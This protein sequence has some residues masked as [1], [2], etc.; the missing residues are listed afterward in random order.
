MNYDH[1]SSGKS[2]HD[3]LRTD[4]NRIF[5]YYQKGVYPSAER[6]IVIGDIHGDW[7]AFVN[8]LK[9]SKII[10]DKLEYIGGKTHIVQVGDVFDRKPRE[11]DGSCDEDSEMKIISLIMDLQIKSYLKGGGYHPIIGNHELMNVLG[12]FSYASPLGLAHFGGAKGR[13][14][15]FQ[16]GSSLSKYMACGWNPIVKIGGWLFCHGGISKKVA[17]KYDIENINLIMR[18]YL[19]G[20]T[21][22][23]GRKYFDELFLNSQSILWNRDYSTDH[24]KSTYD[25]LNDDLNYVLKKYNAKRICNGHTPQM[26]GI[27]H[28]FNGRVFNVDTGMSEAFGKKNDRLERIHFMEIINDQNK[29]RIY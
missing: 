19:Y 15:F 2:L 28:R 8:V 22:H 17:E 29:I 5:E 21:S 24:Y 4:Y 3:L 20:N 12:E 16:P 18:D 13:K 1:L 23:Y 25:K 6:M 14:Q 11:C 7:N 9:K 10:N 26:G 27:K